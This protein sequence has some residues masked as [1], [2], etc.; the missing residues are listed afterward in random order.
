LEDSF[1]VLAA[2]GKSNIFCHSERSEESLFGLNAGKERF[3]ALTGSGL[4]ITKN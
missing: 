4:G 2:C 1:G 3:L